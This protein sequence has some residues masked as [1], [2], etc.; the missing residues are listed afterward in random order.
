MTGQRDKDRERKNL[1]RLVH[2]AD[3]TVATLQGVVL[4]T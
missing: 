2:D 1:E 4:Q 3:T